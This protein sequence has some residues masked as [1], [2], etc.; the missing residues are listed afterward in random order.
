[1]AEPLGGSATAA[2]GPPAL[3]PEGHWYVPLAVVAALVVVLAVVAGVGVA[4]MRPP[5]PQSFAPGSPSAAFA[6]YVAAVR[7]DLALTR[8]PVA[9]DSPAP[10]DVT[11]A[12]EPA[13]GVAPAPE[14]PRRVLIVS[15]PAGA[16][17]E[18]LR[19]ALAERVPIGYSVRI[20]DEREV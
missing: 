7:R 2:S 18:A 14:K 20:A 10:A 19:A 5:A 8:R 17:L 11:V 13:A 9:T 15:G 12:A 1:M 3:G 16:D 6:A 4:A